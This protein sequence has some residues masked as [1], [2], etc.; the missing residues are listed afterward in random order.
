MLSVTALATVAQV[1]AWL[2]AGLMAALFVCYDHR[3]RVD[4]DEDEDDG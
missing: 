3:R 2:V 1:A 4:L